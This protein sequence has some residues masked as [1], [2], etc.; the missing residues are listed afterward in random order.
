VWSWHY[1]LFGGAVDKDAKQERHEI[2]SSVPPLF[3]SLESKK[4]GKHQ[5]FSLRA[6]TRL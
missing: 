2:T 5:S 3:P 1:A 6:H 4:E